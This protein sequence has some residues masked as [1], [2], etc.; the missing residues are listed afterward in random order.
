MENLLITLRHT[1]YW[2]WAVLGY[3]IYAGVKASQPRRQSL[4]RMLVVPMVFMVWGVSAIFHTLQLPLAAVG[5]FLLM[6]VIGLSIGWIWGTTSGIYLPEPRCFQRTG[7]WWPLVLML[8][9][10]C[11]RFYFSVQLARFPTLAHDPVFCLL[12]GAVGGITAGIFSGVSLRLLN[13]MRKI[14]PSL[15]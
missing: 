8:L 1:P 14:R 3:L 5:G 6:L 10:F 15:T 4:V 2:V 11:F 9:T 7:S 13:Q 12:S